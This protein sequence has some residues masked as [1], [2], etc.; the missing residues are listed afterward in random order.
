MQ[1]PS[2]WPDECPPVD[3]VIPH[4]DFFRAIP[5]ETPKKEHFYNSE[6][7]GKF[8]AAPRC[9]RLAISMLK[10]WES[11]KHHLELFTHKK[12]WFVAKV[13]LND[14]HGKIKDSPSQKQPEHVSWWAFE[15]VEKEKSVVEVKRP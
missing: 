15:G 11:A 9:K 8:L 10:T 7:D 12:N 3:A 4:G 2:D 1:F 5:E 14:K 13:N 6:E